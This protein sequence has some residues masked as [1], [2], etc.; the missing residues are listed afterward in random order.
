MAARPGARAAER[1]R[2]GTALR[3]VLQRGRRGPRCGGPGRHP[4]AVRMGLGRA[5]GRRRGMPSRRHPLL[6]GS[7]AAAIAQIGRLAVAGHARPARRRP[8]RRARR[9]QCLPPGRGLGAAGSVGPTSR[10]GWTAYPGRCC[11]ST[12]W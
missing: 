12:T 4:S 2:V 5:T 1:S 9:Q 6:V 10:A 11:S 8:D 7:L 3:E